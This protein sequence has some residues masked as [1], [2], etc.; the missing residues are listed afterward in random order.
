MQLNYLPEEVLLLVLEKCTAQDLTALAQTCTYFAKL[1]QLDSIWKELCKKDYN[2]KEL[3]R[4]E[5]YFYLYSQLL[6]RHGWM[7]GFF[8][9]QTSHNGGL[10]IVKYSNG[11]IQGVQ[12][13]FPVESFNDPLVHTV[14]FE[15][16]VGQK[17]PKCLKY[18]YSCHPLCHRAELRK[19][20][21]D[22]FIYICKK[23][24]SH[25]IELRF[26]Y[27]QYQDDIFKGATYKRLNIS[28]A[29]DT[30]KV[31]KLGNGSLSHEIFKPGFFLTLCNSSNTFGSEI[32]FF[33]IDDINYDIYGVKVAG[34]PNAYPRDLTMKF[35]IRFP[36]M[37]SL[38]EQSCAKTLRDNYGALSEFTVK[39]ISEHIF[40]VPYGC[41][42]YG[43]DID[44]PAMCKARYYGNCEVNYP[45]FEN[46]KFSYPR[47]TDAHLIIFNNDLIGILWLRK[48]RFMVY[49]R[50]FIF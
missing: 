8:Q 33:R 39:D 35:D 38:E 30:S 26:K 13:S 28:N 20:D 50:K 15:L 10:L 45:K 5:N 4:V 24:F 6:H 9:C 42:Q 32:V 41:H 25:K 44:L 27:A 46:P 21:N 23:S 17:D 18:A 3:G 14:M 37:P 19:F 36:I 12:W 22:Y 48:T 16:E 29:E 49:R 11:V 2:V 7:I 31:V 40:V 1:V 43:G 34:D 47:N